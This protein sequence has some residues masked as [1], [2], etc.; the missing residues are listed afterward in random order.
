M[1]TPN[2][3]T[4][5][6]EGVLDSEVDLAK[7]FE[8]MKANTSLV[9]MDFIEAERLGIDVADVVLEEWTMAVGKGRVK[10]G[11]SWVSAGKITDLG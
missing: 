11:D 6:V 7:A 5:A 3:I 4:Q 8:T 9:V 2:V 1:N 10:L